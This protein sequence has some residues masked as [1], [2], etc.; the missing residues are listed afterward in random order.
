[1]TDKISNFLDWKT[2][3]GKI[4]SGVALL[5]ISGFLIMAGGYLRNTLVFKD[6][7]HNSMRDQQSSI[8]TQMAVA[9]ERN[10]KRIESIERTIMEN[11]REIITKLDSLILKDATNAQIIKNILEEQQRL[12]NKSDIL[13]SRLRDVEIQSRKN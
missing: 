3:S 10:L 8:Y 9:E 1:M 4:A 2:I 12:R 5:I 11:N 6:E 13:E 7:F